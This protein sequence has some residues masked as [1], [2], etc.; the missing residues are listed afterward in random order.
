MAYELREACDDDSRAIIGIFN[1]FVRESLAAY[2]AAEVGPE[3]FLGVR[4]LLG[5]YPFLVAECEKRIVGF[6]FLRPY[7]VADSFKRTAEVTYFIV[8]DHTRRGL[9]T[10]F[11]E[12]LTGWARGQGVDNIVASISSENEQSLTFHRKHG[13]VECGRLRGVGRKLGHDF[14]VVWMQLVL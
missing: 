5:H 2:P 1:H 12:R 8:P 14:D 9:G 6:A 4:N 11:L 13:F 10:R 3:F 7:H